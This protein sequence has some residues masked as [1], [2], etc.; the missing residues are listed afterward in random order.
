MP[1]QTP[2]RTPAGD[3]LT[4]LVLLVFRLNSALVEIG[5]LVTHDPNIIA[6]RWRILSL[7]SAGPQTAAELGRELGLSRQGALLNVRV[8][9]ELG[10]V[11]L[12]ENPEDQR[13][14]RVALTS[15]G[16]T[17]LAAVSAHQSRWI[18]DLARKFRK[19][20][21]EGAIEVLE[22]LRR[23]APDSVQVEHD[24]D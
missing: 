3:A 16:R 1:K 21:V 14:M 5:P 23:L 12:V 10:Y 24:P 6:V 15:A 13:A 18:N 19:A 22:K 9:E 4:Q 11:E 17:K 7:V 2:Q 20:E 8:L